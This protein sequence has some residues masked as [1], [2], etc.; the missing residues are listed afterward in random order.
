MT[1]LKLIVSLVFAASLA[2]CSANLHPETR[3][4]GKWQA[5]GSIFGTGAGYSDMQFEFFADGSVAASGKSQT[6]WR[7]EATG[8]FKFVDPTH[9]KID[10]GWFRGTTIYEMDWRDNDHVTLRMTENQI[11]A[12]HRVN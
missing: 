8:T 2:A 4:L 7:Q 9:V 5:R 3:L 6:G 10:L 11:I 12:L 1:T